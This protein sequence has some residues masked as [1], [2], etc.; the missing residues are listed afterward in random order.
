MSKVVQDILSSFVLS[1]EV[2]VR[3][4]FGERYL[5]FGKAS[6]AISWYFVLY[7]VIDALGYIVSIFGSL[8]S[9][10]KNY[11]SVA[12]VAESSDSVSIFF[13]IFLIFVIICLFLEV[14]KVTARKK[15]GE[16]F[17]SLSSG[18]ERDWVVKVGK[19]TRIYQLCDRMFGKYVINRF[20]T[21]L[22]VEPVIFFGAGVVLLFVPTALSLGAWLILGSIIL[23]TKS[24]SQYN[25][26][27]D[28]YLDSIDSQM[29]AQHFTDALSGKKAPEERGYFTSISASHPINKEQKKSAAA[30]MRAFEENNPNLSKHMKSKYRMPPTYTPGK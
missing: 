4:N 24:H 17:Q 27:K 1:F 12:K 22:F 5:N 13:L 3:K 2:L 6:Q 23:A 28:Q 14:R 9:A 21:Q 10:P 15:S 30:S 7:L 19:V 8:Y 29:E 11:S 16:Q 25:R 20:I 26:F 18:V